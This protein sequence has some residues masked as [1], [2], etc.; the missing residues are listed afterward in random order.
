MAAAPHELRHRLVRRVA[1]RDPDNDALRRALRAAAVVPLAAALS[2][3]VAGGS[4]Q[5]P[6]FTIFG[7]TAL[8]VFS[9]FPG[10]RQNRAVA[11]AGLGFNGF[12]LITLGTLV[13]PH[14]W[15]AVAVMFALGVVVTFSGVLSETIAAGQR[16]TLLTFVLPACTPAGP[17]GERLLGWA[18]A[19]AVCVPAALFVLPPR[20]HG[21]LRRRAARACR[22]LADRL[23]GSATP[24]DVQ[25]AMD[26]LRA[27][28][29]GADFRP[30]GLTAGSRALVRVV[31]DL[32][33]VADRVGRNTGVALRDKDAVVRVLR[34]AAAVLQISRP[35]DRDAAR[36]DLEAALI[37]L[38]T[39]A[40]GRWRDDL[41]AILSAPD[42]A[43]AVDLGRDLLRR[44]TIAATIGAT[45][46]VISAAAA[47][48]ARPVWARALGLRLPPTGASDRLLPETVAAAQI[49]SGFLANRSVAV[50]NS[51][52]TGL[53]LALAV[54][55]THLFPV[56][57][58]F[59]V[60]LGALSVLRSSAL[61]TGTRVWRAVFGTAIG[62]L[63][64]AVLIS[65]V[66]VNPVLLW[67]LMP[68]VVFG[69]AYVPEIASFTA[70]QAAFTM[71]VLI[72]FNLIAPTG[73]QVG[74]IRVEDV[75]MGTLVAAAVSMLLW[76]RGATASVTRAIDSARTVFA[77]Y[78]RTA[79][80]R[81]TRGASEARTDEVA[82][83]SH[84][85]LAASRVIDDAVRQYLS[86]SSGETDFRAPIVRSFN[87][88]IRLRGAADLV[89]DIPTPP[90]L[91]TY[92]S[93][94]AVVESHA[95]AIC[96]RVAGRADPE[97]SWEPI[98]DD[99]VRALRSEARG[100]DLGLSAA[101]PLLT[102][103]AALGELELIYPRPATG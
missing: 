93:V 54:A 6:L 51:L 86:E 13:A 88:A 74:L 77:T 66:G 71:M 75:V 65:L 14:P 20:H 103:A 19:L 76:P 61:T 79:V 83:R 96:E 63:L 26:A 92:P 68:V 50:R 69:S 43:Q 8:L 100:D 5:T 42:D 17:V 60:V 31:D 87:R 101:L 28:F 15:P 70:A 27:T 84:A 72:F 78:L 7:S 73:W 81:I 40:R 38:R 12:V 52:R 2:F 22:A 32:E 24:A 85:A 23:D 67:L 34:C 102:A 56:E 59:W 18:I 41:D 64:G 48:D 39:V 11:Y 1:Q 53:G 46:R 47:A 25:R 37:T 16:A 99:F 49:T 30:V 94:R 10:N 89:A 44:R 21:Q 95:D 90:P 33:W 35:A 57:H 9:D 62:F 4:A 29:L 98:S 80:L 55:V 3:A 36:A 82:T 91:G 45:G 58:G 97:H